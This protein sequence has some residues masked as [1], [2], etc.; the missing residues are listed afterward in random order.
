[1]TEFLTALEALQPSTITPLARPVRRWKPKRSAVLT[2]VAVLA[3]VGGGTYVWWVIPFSAKHPGIAG[4]PATAT[5]F[6]K[7]QQSI[8]LV[9][10]WDKE[11][12]LDRGIA[13]L[14]DATTQ[15]PKFALGFARLAEA[16]RLK[17]ALT[18][19]KKWLDTAA[20]N[21]E[22]AVQLNGDLAPVHVVAGRIQLAQTKR[23][24]AMA[25]FQHALRIDPNDAEA[26]QAIG[27]LYQ[28]LSRPADAD[29]SLRR[30]VALDPDNVFILDSYA[31]FLFAQGRFEDAI[32]QWQ[33]E[34][35][36]APDNAPALINLGSALSETGRIAEAITMYQR[37]VAIRPNYMAFN[38]LGTA[39]FRSVHYPEAGEAYRKALDLDA[40]DFIVWGGL[41]YA[42]AWT[43]G[44]ETEARQAFAKAIEL[45]EAQRQA[46]PR[47]A[48]VASHLAAF[49]AK[50]GQPSLALARIDTALA[51]MPKGPDVQASAAEVYE[52]VGRRDKALEAAR[53][54]L[55]LGYGRNRLER[56][57]EL[58]KLLQALRQ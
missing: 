39:Y 40:R 43:P 4:A 7:Y 17:Y 57:P 23:D 53:Q 55:A 32:A 8:D 9:R 48:A 46:N 45:G 33:A 21:A 37:A 50:S 41:G 58:T 22:R 51:L 49:Y 16:Q 20:A 25:S 34:I 18:R 11:G 13:L 29:A 1:M 52:L 27:R 31:N 56:N 6:D 15:D 3:V 2:L 28:Q 36:L 47:D 10:R 26:N 35:R 54:A 14:T 5:V 38:N 24:L 30:A 42:Y 44:K 19:D 12:N